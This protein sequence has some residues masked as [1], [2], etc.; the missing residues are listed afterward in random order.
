ML[1]LIQ[2][3]VIKLIKLFMRKVSKYLNLRTELPY[4]PVL[5]TSTAKGEW[6]QGDR[7]LKLERGRVL[8]KIE[9]PHFTNWP[10]V[11]NSSSLAPK[12]TS[13]LFHSD[14]KFIIPCNSSLFLFN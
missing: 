12:L 14:P 9:F 5:L 11:S 7:A 4:A 1:Q 3:E 2:I 8:I 10:P 6:G 13:V